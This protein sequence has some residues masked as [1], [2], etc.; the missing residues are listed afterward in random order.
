MHTYIHTYIHGQAKDKSDYKGP[1]RVNPGPKS[2]CIYKKP[3]FH[4]IALSAL[5]ENLKKF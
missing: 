3:F 5:S 4:S 2:N 1:Q